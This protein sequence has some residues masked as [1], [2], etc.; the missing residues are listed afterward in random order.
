MASGE[1]IRKIAQTAA[2]IVAGPIGLVVFSPWIPK[3]GE[4]F[5]VWVSLL[6]VLLIVAVIAMILTASKHEGYWYLIT[7]LN[8]NKIGLSD[9]VQRKSCLLVLK[10][11]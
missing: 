10:Q 6:V 5:V 1:K 11:E 3:T 9:A 8:P 2:K 4:G 7:G